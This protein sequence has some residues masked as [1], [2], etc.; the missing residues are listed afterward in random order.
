M[1][2]VQ[3]LSLRLPVGPQRPLA[4]GRAQLPN[5]SLRS[6]HPAT[7]GQLKTCDVTARKLCDVTL[8]AADGDVTECDV[9]CQDVAGFRGLRLSE[10]Q[11]KQSGA[12]GGTTKK[13]KLK[14]KK[15]RKVKVKPKAVK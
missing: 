5:S 10:T 14:V 11:P 3:R 12:A 2:G 6:G 13:K 1:P 4:V 7:R 9:T 15:G 8:P